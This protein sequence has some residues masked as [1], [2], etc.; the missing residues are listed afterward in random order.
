MKARCVEF[1]PTRAVVRLEPNWIARAL[2]ARAVEIELGRVKKPGVQPGTCRFT[3]WVY[4]GSGRELDELPCASR[5]R[6]ALDFREVSAPTE[7]KA[8]NAP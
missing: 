6:D 5:I 4:P 2:G 7:A 1:A 3:P 8:R